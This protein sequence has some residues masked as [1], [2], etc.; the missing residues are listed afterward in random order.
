VDFQTLN[1]IAY[2]RYLRFS[3]FQRKLLI[4]KE[5]KMLLKDFIKQLNKLDQDV[6]IRFG[7][8]NDNYSEPIIECTEDTDTLEFY[9]RIVGK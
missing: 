6:E 2:S 5:V 7:L 8:S 9:Y 1:E 3:L 4:N